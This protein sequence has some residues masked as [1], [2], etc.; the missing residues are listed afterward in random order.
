[1]L[2]FRFCLFFFFFFDSLVSFIVY[3]NTYVTAL[4]GYYPQTRPQDHTL[5]QQTDTKR[6]FH[7]WTQKNNNKNAK[8]ET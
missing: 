5:D 1:L 2:V 4:E 7:Y 6:H 3:Q 8:I